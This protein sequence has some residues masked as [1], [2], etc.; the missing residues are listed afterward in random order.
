MKAIRV[1]SYPDTCPALLD[2]PIPAIQDGWVRIKNAYSALNYKDMLAI[3]GKG[4]ILR[5]T[6]LTPGIDCAG[7]IDGTSDMHL[8]LGD[9]VIAIG[10]GI[11][12]RYDGGLAEY[13]LAPVNAIIRLPQGW[14][15]KIAMQYGTAGFSAA[16]AIERLVCSGITPDMG[17]IAVTGAS[18]AVGL[19]AVRMLSYLGYDTLAITNSI[20]QHGEL[21][22]RMG[23]HRLSSYAEFTADQKPLQSA[24]FAGGIDQTGGRGLAAMLARIQPHGA[25]CSI[26]MADSGSLSASV[27]PF[28]L[29]GITLHGIT[30]TN[31]T[32]T[33]RQRIIDWTTRYFDA[34]FLGQMP[35]SEIHL[36]ETLSQCANWQQRGA[37]RIIV[38]IDG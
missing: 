30:S 21:L 17:E 11:G 1:Q 28:I 10:A 8:R 3:T 37:G 25:V 4:K 29:R 32:P 19:W 20:D 36:S 15:S 16:C 13:T 7:S 12:E 22:Y 34:D 31:I 14:N 5:S 2:M 33:G 6:P 23:A 9:S 24:V 35:Y 38:N 27:M 26:G 18:G